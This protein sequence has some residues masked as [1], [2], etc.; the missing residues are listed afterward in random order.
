MK[1]KMIGNIFLWKNSHMRVF[2][3]LYIFLLSFIFEDKKE[4]KKWECKY[5]SKTRFSS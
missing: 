2:I 1:Y 5:F 3:L 4:H